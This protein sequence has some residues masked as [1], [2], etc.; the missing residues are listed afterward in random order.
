METDN[1]STPPGHLR[2]AVTSQILTHTSQS[3]AEPHVP[4]LH[5]WESPAQRLRQRHW[6]FE[7]AQP[8]SE[9]AVSLSVL[10]KRLTKTHQVLGAKGDARVLASPHPRPWQSSKHVCA[11]PAGMGEHHKHPQ[12]SSLSPPCTQAPR[13]TTGGPPWAPPIV[14]VP[15]IAKLPAPQGRIL[16]KAG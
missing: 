2:P 12:G 7:A 8:R 14:S 15:Q 13:D 4:R 3:P 11:S 16:A 1:P 5:T 9:E 10:A 6:P